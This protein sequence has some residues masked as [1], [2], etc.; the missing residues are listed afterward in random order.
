VH[1]E[2]NADGGVQY[3]SYRDLAIRFGISS[4]IVADYARRHNC[5]RRREELGKRAREIADQRVLA[6]RADSIAGEK[7]SRLKLLHTYFDEFAKSLAEG[8][9]RTDNIADFDKACRLE[10]FLLGDAESRREVIQ[11]SALQQWQV[12]DAELLA[13]LEELKL[14]PA[15]TGMVVKDTRTVPVTDVIDAEF[16]EEK[17]SE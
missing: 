8:R 14:K 11:G 5:V 4:S 1:G 13:E 16:E 9:V 17:S 15:L 10:A 2:V 3:P 12:T 7:Q 6:D